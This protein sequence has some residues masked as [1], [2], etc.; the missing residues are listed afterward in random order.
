M[1]L[2][3]KMVLEFVSRSLHTFYGNL[4]VYVLKVFFTLLLHSSHRYCNLQKECTKSG[5][6]L[7]GIS[8]PWKNT[9]VDHRYWRIK[10]YV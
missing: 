7:Y 4:H 5:H 2:D 9:I 10:L 3:V 8:S 1:D 6:L